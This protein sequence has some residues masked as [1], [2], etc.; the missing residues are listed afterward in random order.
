M[1]FF[2]QGP[3]PV[4]AAEKPAPAVTFA[5]ARTRRA[6]NGRGRPLRNGPGRQPK[7]KAGRTTP[8]D[9]ISRTKKSFQP[10]KIG[11]APPNLPPGI[12][13]RRLLR[14]EICQ[15]SGKSN[16]DSQMHLTRSRDPP[17][18]LRARVLVLAVSRL[19][20]GTCFS[21]EN[22][23]GRCARLGGTRSTLQRVNCCALLARSLPLPRSI[24][25]VRCCLY[26]FERWIR[27]GGG[28]LWCRAWLLEH[29]MT[30]GP[31]R[32]DVSASQLSR[33]NLLVTRS[34]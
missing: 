26:K 18:L 11:C 9:F 19:P 5:P 12:L 15:V 3:R 14:A 1:L 33:R 6:S 8:G 4:L 16:A 28:S 22:N 23:S 20:F 2:V 32:V 34:L 31:L 27:V 24:A 25:R 7:G 29:S 21:G 13:Q 10:G 17:A 30:I